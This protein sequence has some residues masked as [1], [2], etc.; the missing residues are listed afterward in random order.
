MKRNDLRVWD[1][2]KNNV[3]DISGVEKPENWLYERR[4][5]I[6][7]PVEEVIVPEGESEEEK[8]MFDLLDPDMSDEEIEGL[9]YTIK[10]RSEVE[11]DNSINYRENCGHQV[12]S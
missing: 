3:H 9:G 4:D 2:V 7:Y 11:G 6:F 10:Y 1:I 8:Q 5:G 12:L